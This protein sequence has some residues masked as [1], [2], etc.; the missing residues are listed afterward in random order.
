MSGTE[1]RPGDASSGGG[2]D[3]VVARGR[4]PTPILPKMGE[5]EA[6]DCKM[7]TMLGGF[8]SLHPLLPPGPFGVSEG[9]HAVCPYMP[10]SPAG[11]AEGQDSKVQIMKDEV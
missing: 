3:G 5:S 1:E 2:D 7:P 11:R 9:E 4:P 8:A 10:V 6:V